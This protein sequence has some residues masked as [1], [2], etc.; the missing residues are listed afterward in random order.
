MYHYYGIIMMYYDCFGN[1][2]DINALKKYNNV[3]IEL[4][5]VLQKR[6]N[7]SIQNI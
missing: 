6:Y 5:V 2:L 1:K 3:V 4:K 7:N